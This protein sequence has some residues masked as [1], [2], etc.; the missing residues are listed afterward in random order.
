MSLDRTIPPK[1]KGFDH[2]K[3]QQPRISTLDNGI[4]L[5]V[6]DQ[7]HQEVNRLTMMWNGGGYDVDRPC[8]LS[9]SATMLNEGTT[10]KSSTEIAEILDFNGAWIKHNVNSHHTSLALYSLNSKLRDVLPTIVECID[11]P[12]F[13][14]KEF[15]VNKEK[16]ACQCELEQSKVS[17]HSSRDSHR[18]I[19]GEN[20]PTSHD[21]TP[22]EIR[23]I[24][25]D[26]IKSL[27]HLV[28]TPATCALF[29][30][31]RITPAIED[32]INDQFGKLQSSSAGMQQRII[33]IVPSEQRIVTTQRP[34]SLQSAITFAIPTVKRSHPDYVD[35]RLAV[36]A[37][38]GYFGSRLMT[39]IREDKGYT[40]DISAGL[41]GNWECGVISISTQCDNRYV[42]S[43]I[44]E[45][46]KE[47]VRMSA[48]DFTD[49][50]LERMKQ[51]AM[52]QLAAM[53]DSPFSTMDYYENMR[54]LCT[55]DD[56]FEQQ[57][58]AIAKISSHRI[59]SLAEK[60]MPLDELR[61]AIAGNVQQD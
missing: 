10:S 19:Y 2:L 4:P 24:G 22:Q 18:M 26:E 47:L 12:S 42:P 20:H 7:G 9:L 59:A 31:G 44:D 14:Q 58:Q 37:L 39:N 29:V 25:I 1:I 16:A 36:M 13:P 48:D 28:F 52:S 49:V 46:K 61:I 56:Y 41:L 51:F 6:I 38:G 43:V 53:L 5:T 57:Q 23:G 32:Y 35:L 45:V 8:A 21:E 50:E 11:S 34:D 33:P 54:L 15:E 40:Y 17:Y 3:I 27:H 55:P 30:A 60:Y